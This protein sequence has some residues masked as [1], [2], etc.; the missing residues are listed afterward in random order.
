MLAAQPGW[1]HG[2]H[3]HLWVPVRQDHQCS[4]GPTR[5]AVRNEVLLLEETG[6]SRFKIP[7]VNEE[8]PVATAGRHLGFFVKRKGDS[9]SADQG[10]IV[11]GPVADAI[12]K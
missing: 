3:S 2:C 1:K 4:D 12:L 5:H 6:P 9:A 10:L 11:I 8:V 7:W